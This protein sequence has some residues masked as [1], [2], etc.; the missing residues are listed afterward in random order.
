MEQDKYWNSANPP[1]GYEARSS[2]GNLGRVEVDSPELAEVL[3]KL[4]AWHESQVRGLSLVLEHKDASIDLGDHSIE[5]GTELHRGVRIGVQLALAYLGKL[6]VY[7]NVADDNS[8]D[9]T[10]DE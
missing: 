9:D 4:I 8:D 5:A 2:S 3:R 7:F 6:P 1:K 10:D